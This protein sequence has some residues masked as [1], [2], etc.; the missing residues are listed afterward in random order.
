MMHVG[1]HFSCLQVRVEFLKWDTWGAR[2]DMCLQ[3]SL[4]REDFL[5]STPGNFLLSP[6]ER[7]EK[8]GG[9]FCIQG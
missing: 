1:H 7:I 6:S 4:Q 2:Q 9:E 3:S 5:N 8:K